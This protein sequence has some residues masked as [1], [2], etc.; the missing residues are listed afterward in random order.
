MASVI[1]SMIEMILLRVGHL[2]PVITII[3]S[4]IAIILWIWTFMHSYWSTSEDTNG[5]VQARCGPPLLVAFLYLIYLCCAVG[6]FR[7]KRKG[8]KIGTSTI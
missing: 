1:A 2:V 5:I 8:S 6:A 7:L 3:W 4:L